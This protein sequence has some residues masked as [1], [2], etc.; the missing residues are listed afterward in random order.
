MGHGLNDAYYLLSGTILCGSVVAG[1]FFFRFWNRTG[2]RFFAIFGVA[3][4][5]M[6]IE[7]IVIAM[8]PGFDPEEFSYAYLIRLVAFVLILAAIFD[9]NRGSSSPG[10]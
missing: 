10:G 8:L 4:W 5:I 3:F 6:A 7:R 2:D 1:T 9:K